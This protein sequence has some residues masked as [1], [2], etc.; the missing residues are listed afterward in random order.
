MVTSSHLVA[1][2]IL[3][4]TVTEILLYP[5]A[6]AN[7]VVTKAA[8]P[9]YDDLLKQ[10]HFEA[11]PL[12]TSHPPL[13]VLIGSY[14]C[15]IGAFLGILKPGRVSLIGTLLVVWGLFK[16]DTL[17]RPSYVDAEEV[18]SIYPSM[19]VAV[20]FAFMS[21]RGD[22]RKIIRSCRTGQPDPR[23]PPCNHSEAK[24]E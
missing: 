9:S 18:T 13:E 7:A 17:R 3:P 14:L 8:L 24:L 21:I 22:V 11:S 5:G 2:E 10:Y 15:V 19:C 4:A 23:K 20:T 12:A 6:V 1:N 16:K